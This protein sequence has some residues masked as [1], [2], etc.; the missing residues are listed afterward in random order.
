M[1]ICVIAIAIMRTH[2]GAR[3]RK[4]PDPAVYCTGRRPDAAGGWAR[5]CE[6]GTSA[7]RNGWLLLLSS[8]GVALWADVRFGLECLHR[9]AGVHRSPVTSPWRT[10]TRLRVGTRRG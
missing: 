10:G 7:Q 5:A 6:G 9:S 2:G 4:A 1:W 3:E 8:C